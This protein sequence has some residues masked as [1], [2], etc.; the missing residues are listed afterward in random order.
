MVKTEL[1]RVKQ[2]LADHR[3]HQDDRESLQGLESA[4][5]A[6]EDKHALLFVSSRVHQAKLSAPLLS[7]ADM[8]IVVRD[9]AH[10][11]IE[12]EIQS[13]NLWINDLLVDIYSL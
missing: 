6:A 1:A 12:V 8:E 13:I 2:V 5:E 7:E 3:R 9:E 4:K 11:L 10:K